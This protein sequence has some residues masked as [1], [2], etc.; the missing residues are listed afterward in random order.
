MGCAWVFASVR[1]CALCMGGPGCDGSVHMYAA[2]HGCALVK[3][4]VC[5]MNFQNTFWRL[6]S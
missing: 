1:R 6:E 3:A 4:I 5:G 2:T